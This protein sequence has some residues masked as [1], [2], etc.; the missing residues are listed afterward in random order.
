MK[1][2]SIFLLSIGLI[3]ACSSTQTTENTTTKNKTPSE[4]QTRTNSSSEIESNDFKETLNMTFKLLDAME[5]NN[6]G[7]IESVS[8][9]NVRIDKQKNILV[10]EEG[11]VNFLTSVDFNNLEYRFFEKK[12]PDTMVIGLAKITDYAVEIYFYFN[13]VEGKWLFNGFFT[14]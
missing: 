6:Y 4:Q 1:K 12:D 7:Y 11:E 13:K 8:S 10:S 9:P 2:S 14:N 5:S 3:T